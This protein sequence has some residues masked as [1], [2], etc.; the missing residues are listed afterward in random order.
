MFSI[1]GSSTCT[2]CTVEED[3]QN[4]YITAQ[5]FDRQDETNYT[6]SDCATSTASPFPQLDVCADM[7][8]GLMGDI[9]LKLQP[10]P[11]TLVVALALDFESLANPDAREQFEKG[12]KDD[13]ALN[14]NVDASR[15]LVREVRPVNDD[16]TGRRLQNTATSV[17]FEILP[18]TEPGAV[19]SADLGAHL[20]RSASS[21]ELAGVA[22]ANLE[23]TVDT[24]P[25]VPGRNSNCTAGMYLHPSGLCNLCPAGTYDHDFN[26]DTQCRDCRDGYESLPG[27]T[28][29]YGIPCTDGA[30]ILHSSTTCGD[31]GDDRT[32]AQCEYSCNAGYSAFGAHVC[33][34]DGWWRGGMCLPN[35]CNT[36]LTIENS[37]TRC[38]G[39]TGERCD[40]TCDC[41]FE[42]SGVH[43][44]GPDG[45][46]AGGSCHLCDNGFVSQG[47]GCSRC[48]N[49]QEPD[50]NGCLC[51]ACAPGSA[52]MRGTCLQCEGGKAPSDDM[53]FCSDCAAG[54]VS[55]G[56]RCTSCGPGEFTRDHVNCVQA[57]DGFRPNPRL[58]EE[59]ACPPQHVGV[60]GLC[61]M[62][63]PGN[64]PNEDLTACVPCR[65]RTY[66]SNGIECIPCP[67]DGTSI[68][69]PNDVTGS[70]FC[71]SCDLRLLHS[72]RSLLPLIGQH[73]L[74]PLQSARSANKYLRT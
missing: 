41:G 11:V 7:M 68:A 65:S 51:Q 10:P 45:A 17:D 49:G 62:C 44:C 36:S 12:F 9:G 19:A 48:D 5:V 73:A 6:A 50:E 35:A 21:L 63:G 55:A 37:P 66:N 69:V 40:F 71:V 14:L 27:S 53:T 3:I 28:E 60:G 52:G 30:I 70:T 2:V 74:S 64:E 33:N 26:R 67:R 34:P 54:F 39:T 13:V 29:C 32:G 72:G 61:E 43:Q 22:V 24:V 57:A 15:I 58:D 1:P 18:S 16:G 20:A 25:A 38:S 59:E 47:V 56:E 42:P 46:F 4:D 31:D 8:L 23:V